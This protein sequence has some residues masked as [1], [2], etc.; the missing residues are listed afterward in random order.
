MSNSETKKF[1]LATLTFKS[2]GPEYSMENAAYAVSRRFFRLAHL[3]P[4]GQALTLRLS[5]AEC[6]VFSDDACHMT[7]EDYIWIF[8]KRADVSME[9]KSMLSP[10]DSDGRL[11][12][13]LCPVPGKNLAGG[14]DR[15]NAIAPQDFEEMLQMLLGAGAVIELAAVSR[16]AGAQLEC[17]LLISLPGAMPLRMNS[18]ISLA[19]FN[20]VA[21]ETSDYSKAGLL[22]FIY[23]GEFLEN[24]VSYCSYKGAA[25]GDAE[26]AFEEVFDD[27]FPG[28]TEED[29][30]P[31]EEFA[32][33]LRTYNQLK[34]S[35]I[36]FFEQLK[37]MND[38]EIADIRGLSWKSVCEVREIV[39][40]YSN[41]VK[42]ALL[43]G[44]NY[45]DMLSELVGLSEVK[46]QVRRLAAFARLKKDKG[47]SLSIALNMAFLGNPGTCKTTVARIVAGVF[48]EIGL[49]KSSSIVE[50]GRADL[51]AGYVGQTAEKVKKVFANARGKVLFIDE[52]YSLLDDDE[53]SYGDEA[54]ATIVQ[55]MENNRDNTVVIF[56]GYPD[57]MKEFISRNPGLRSRVPFTVYF[58]DYSC[59][60]LVGIAGLEVSRKGF[61][62]SDDALIRLNE[63]LSKAAGVPELGNGRFVRNLV[64]NAVLNYAAR[65]YGDGNTPSDNDMVLIADDFSIPS[66]LMADKKRSIGFDTAA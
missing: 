15:R 41:T 12:Y 59:D 46:E 37:D 5:K 34:R 48:Y 8:G 3:L 55:E 32:F 51:I 30:T 4:E 50:V 44:G 40:S 10:L 66:D 43:E 22:P 2:A 19:V 26:A 45:M 29:S 11:V 24:L 38:E 18:L 21:R 62:L 64:E 20:A 16:G 57:R 39:R 36:N 28:L 14:D 1:T 61:K 56:A 63:L 7:E 17:R 65:V 23:Y 42:P 9:E 6:S 25:A 60:E 35:G 58:S 52:A 13:S 49:L 27:G 31:I 53:N 54:I 33:S 47:D